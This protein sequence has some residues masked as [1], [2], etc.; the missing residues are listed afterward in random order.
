MITDTTVSSEKVIIN[1]PVTLVWSIL[2]DFENYEKWNP[3]CPSIKT[4]LEPG[5]PVEMQCDLGH[6]LQKQVEFMTQIEPEK[7]LAWGMKNEPGD[8]VKAIRYQYLEALGDTQCSYY[9]IDEF[10]GEQIAGMLK[11][12]GRNI[13]NGFNACALGLKAIAE[14]RFGQLAKT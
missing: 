12:F 3:F 10:E 1:A 2:V 4:R 5:A 8:P 9:T 13:E 14:A 7:V 6:G 11:N